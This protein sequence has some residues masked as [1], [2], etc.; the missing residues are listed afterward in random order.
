MNPEFKKKIIEDLEKTG[1][2]AEFK[3]R[4]AI[5]NRS[6]RWDSTGTMGY[7]DLDE[8]KLREID[9][10]AFMPCGDRVSRSKHTHTVW[11]LVIEVKKSEN[12]KP[13][14]VF[15][16]RRDVIRDV[17]RWKQDLVSY[18]N[19][20]AEWEKNFS[21]K[22]YESSFCKGMDW[23]GSGIHES[24]KKASN[25]RPFSAMVSVVKAAEHFHAE[26]KKIFQEMPAITDDISE[27][28][29]R[30]FFTRPVIVLDGELL[31]A[32]LDTSGELQVA[33]IDMAPLYVGYRSEQYQ[34][35][36]YRVDLVR[37]SALDD[38]L[39]TVEAQ[40]NGIRKAI[41]ELGGLGEYSED[42]IYNGAKPKKTPA[43]QGS[44]GNG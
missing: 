27:N 24:F 19:L 15:K 12:G 28:P 13:W 5:Y 23:I 18:C 39:A 25:P 20:P 14:V 3:V 8:Q 44:G 29:S 22:V 33:E 17:L 1:Y 4:R 40:H 43:E 11:T 36:N 37:M 2:P 26:Q 16:E 21:W 42:E 38:Y 41:I 7:F 30:V 10:F 32:E 31:S 34:R 6:G 35:E 9:V